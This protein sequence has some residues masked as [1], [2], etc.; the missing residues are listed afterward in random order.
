M[1]TNIPTDKAPEP[2]LLRDYPYY[3]IDS[4]FG[5]VIAEPHWAIL[6]HYKQHQQ[7]LDLAPRGCGKTRIGDIGYAAWKAVN[8][9]NIRILIVSDTDTHA[10]RFLGTIKA[11]LESHP[12]LKQYYGELRGNKWTDHEIVL[13]TRTDKTLT[14]A[15][16]SAMGMYSGAVT[17]GHYSVI[18]ADDLINFDNSRT[19]GQRERSKD[20]FKTTLLPTI[21]PGGEIHCLGTRYHYSDLWDMVQNEFGYH[22]QVQKAIKDDGLS[23]WEKHMPLNDRIDDGRKTE[24]LE[25][26]K[27]TLG[28]VIFALQYQNDT[29]LLKEGN[30]FQYDW[31]Q[32]YDTIPA[33][34]R[35]FQG[36]DPAISQKDTADFFAL[37]TVGIDEGN[38]YVLDIIRERLTFDQQIQMIKRKHNEWQP[39]IVG[40]EKVAYQEALIQHVREEYPEIRVKEIQTIRDKVSRAYNRSGLFENGRIFVRRDMH[41]FIDELVLFPDAQHDD[42]F[43]AFDFALSVADIGGYEQ[44]T[45]EVVSGGRGYRATDE[46][47]V[48]GPRLTRRRQLSQQTRP[49]RV[50]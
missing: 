32:Y 28:S 33:G 7:T 40:I 25:S 41:L 21:L 19:E 44:P 30:V 24:G 2:Q 45:G 49:P 29:Q 14:E 36:V 43:D 16:I 9:P 50:W 12:I 38:I 42:Q 31:F 35:I 48:A 20:W 27:Q 13:K 37:V 10:V 5:Y 46:P 17:T 47:T 1:P 23:I 3:F 22:T 4:I 26:I 11:V 6:T 8:N 15:T 39:L 18:I 34:L